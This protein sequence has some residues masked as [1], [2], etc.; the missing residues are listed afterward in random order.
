MRSARRSPH[1]ERGLKFDEP[2][3]ELQA[4]GSLPSR[5][6]WI[7]I[8]RPARYGQNNLSLPSRGA[9]IEIPQSS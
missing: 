9:W 8:G 6:A 1:G 5:G 3:A 4:T 2:M 7:E